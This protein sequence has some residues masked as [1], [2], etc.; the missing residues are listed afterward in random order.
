[1]AAGQ[2]GG[3]HALFRGPV[4]R[5]PDQRSVDTISEPMSQLKAAVGRR[6]QALER[7]DARRYRAALDPCD[8]R[9]SDA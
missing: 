7:V 8:G 2:A 4:Q 1:M 6:E 9:L 3:R 5:S